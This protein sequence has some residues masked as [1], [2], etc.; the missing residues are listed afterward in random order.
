[1][2]IKAKNKKSFSNTKAGFSLIEM[3]MY[4]FIMLIVA[5]MM[6]SFL[7]QL[8]R[9]NLYMQARGDVLGNAR[10][11]LDVMT[12]EIRHASSIYTP[13]SVF[14]SSFGQLGLETTRGAVEGEETT[15]VDFFVDGDRLYMK[16]EGL[17]A[18]ILVSQKVKLD[19]LTFTH[20]NPSGNY[21]A[22]RISI[23]A[24]YD[25]PSPDIQEKSSTTLS[26]TVSLR[27]Y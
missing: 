10:S 26:T 4:V 13:T 3:I 17:E 23:T 20:I 9:N 15:F 27:S 11:A 7:P 21:Q 19:N 6:A 22:V 18:D 8:V 24:Y 16:K 25:S 12:L 2:F 1:M 5:T 14:G